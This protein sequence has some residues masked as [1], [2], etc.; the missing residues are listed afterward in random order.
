MSE[1]S[2]KKPSVWQAFAQPAAWTM[3]LFGFSSGLPFLLVAG[4]LAYWLKQHGVVL[5]EITVIAS[6]GMLY[7]FKFLWAPLLDHWQVPGFTRLGRRRGW[8]LLLPLIVLPL[9]P[10][11]AVAT[12]WSDLWQRPDQ[13]AAQALKQGQAKQAQQLARDP[14]WR[15]AAAYR[16]GDY[17]AAA[18]A[19]R[20]VRPSASRRDTSRDSALWL[21]CT[22][23]ASSW[24]RR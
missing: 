21:M 24:M 1:P 13:Q 18:Q 17:A 14:A 6:A 4:T 12:T 16:A 23:S 15:G 20:Q 11:T 5:K 8:L 2:R 22:S 9:L 19:L 10:T 3:F 7:V